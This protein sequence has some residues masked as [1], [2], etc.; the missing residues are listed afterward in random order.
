[1][2]N[3]KT[4]LLTRLLCWTSG[5]QMDILQKYPTEIIRYSAMGTIVWLTAIMACLSGGYFFLSAFSNGKDVVL[6]WSGI[7]FG[8]FWGAA[9]FSLDRYMIIS[10]KPGM[11]NWR[12]VLQ[13]IPRLFLAICLGLIVSKPLELKFFE[14]EIRDQIEETNQSSYKERLAENKDVRIKKDEIASFEAEKARLDSILNQRREEVDRLKTDYYN[15]YRGISEGISTGIIGFGPESDRKRQIWEKSQLTFDSLSL[16][17]SQANLS[18]D[19]K[20]E[21]AKKE[22]VLV[23]NQARKSI[24]NNAGPL[25]RIEALAKITSKN[26][27]LRATDLLLSFIFI[28]FEV[29]P[30]V[31]KLTMKKGLYDLELEEFEK[32][33]KKELE[34]LRLIEERKLATFHK[35]EMSRYF[36]GVEKDQKLEKILF[37]SDTENLKADIHNH[38]KDKGKESNKEFIVNKLKEI[39]KNRPFGGTS[40][41]LG[42]TP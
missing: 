19:K 26:G 3:N 25:K 18:L 32:F 9:I 42:K 37:E 11:S 30:I 40:F 21:L 6:S 17:F 5:A 24:D 22:L 2:E 10:I 35:T 39:R 23:R 33:K 1:M 7:G 38:F 36:R 4:N 27:V 16:Q 41:G 34:E 28:L 8:I 20:I 13:V 14:K 29:A 12:S 15:E 31:V